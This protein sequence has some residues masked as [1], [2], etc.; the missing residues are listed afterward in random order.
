[1]DRIVLKLQR[2]SIEKRKDQIDIPTSLGPNSGPPTNLKKNF[3]SPF[4]EGMIFKILIFLQHLRW[5]P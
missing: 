2:E 4:L 3:K 1:V 5:I